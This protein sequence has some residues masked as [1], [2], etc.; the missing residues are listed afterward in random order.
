M[1]ISM[2]KIINYTLLVLFATSVAGLWQACSDDTD[3]TV[4][5]P[6]VKTFTPA[7]G[8]PVNTYVKITGNFLGGTKPT[9]VKFNGVDA[10]VISANANA[11]YV[12]VPAGAST[13][14]ITVNV[15][16]HE[17]STTESFAVT[18]GTPAPGIISFDPSSGNGADETTVTIK[19][20]NFNT[21]VLANEVTFKGSGDTPADDM[22]A[23][24]TSATATEL[25]VK[26]PAGA[27]TG[28]IEVKANGLTGTSESDITVPVPTISSFTPNFTI[29]GGTVV[30][31]G[32]NFSK[33]PENNV[34]YFG[35]V[36]AG[37]SVK[38]EVDDKNEANKLTV[39][40]PPGA[41]SG[42]IIV[43]IDG[44]EGESKDDFTVN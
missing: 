9:V 42:K 31:T 37:P 14:K 7:S 17:G 6:Q 32:T 3:Q 16:G 10:E 25:K 2:K 39:I 24:I 28:K 41:V 4:A 21:S 15:D 18:A 26:V 20:V 34:V 5:N 29:E 8:G 23:T 35:G 11:V 38:V 27:R 19:G 43:S 12:L 44:V 1:N 33:V 22:V 13:G 36:Q 30:I 40:V